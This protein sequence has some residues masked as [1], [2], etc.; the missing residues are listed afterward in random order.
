MRTYKLHLIR[1]GLTQ[2]NLQGTYIG[3]TDVSLTKEGLENLSK[4]MKKYIYPNVD[5]VYTSPL[6]RCVQTAYQL[7]PQVEMKI[8]EQLSEYNFGEFEGK[9]YK[10]LM[11]NEVFLEW[12]ENSKEVAPPNGENSQEFCMRILTGISKIFEHMVSN[13]IHSAAVITHSG[14]ITTLLATIGLP[15]QNIEQRI[16]P[17]GTGFTVLL[18][19]EM[20][21]RSGCFEI[22]EA[23][24]YRNFEIEDT[25][26]EEDFAHDVM[27]DY[28]P[29]KEA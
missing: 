15:K 6:K 14:V 17:D 23:I 13:E 4:L 10:E 9:N 29:E 3:Q 7:F 12:L 26:T 11:Q 1:H 21:H 5:L 16:I 22:F 25:Y 27:C 8:V 2:A 19:P 24:P 20:W 18:T 28:D